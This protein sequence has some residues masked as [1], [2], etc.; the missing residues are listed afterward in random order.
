MKLKDTITPSVLTAATGLLQPYAP[1]LSPSSLVR[2]IRAY[3]IDGAAAA[4][5]NAVR[6]DAPITRKE[7]AKLLGCTLQTI[8]RMMND[9]RLKRIRLSATSVRI[10]ADSLRALLAGDATTADDESEG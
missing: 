3:Q 9:G 6:F 8:S 10:D 4:A 5:G 1:D 7:A 2:A